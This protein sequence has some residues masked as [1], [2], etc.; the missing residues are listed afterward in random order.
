MNQGD[1]SPPGPLLLYIM[2]KKHLSQ[3]FLFDP[4][5]LN[6]IIRAAGVE[7]G[8][9]VVEI[10]PGPGSLTGL[11]TETARRVVAI[12]LDREL[13]ER[14]RTRFALVENIELVSGDALKYDYESLGEPFRVVANIPYHITTPIMFRLL[15]AGPLLKSMTLTVQKEVAERAAA[16]PGSK[17]YGVLSVMLQ[18]HGEVGMKFVIPR[19]AFRPVPKVDSACLHIEIAKKPRVEVADEALFKAVV[20]ASFGQR[21]KTLKNSLGSLDPLAAEALERAGIDPGRRAETLSI[22]DFARVARELS[23]LRQSSPAQ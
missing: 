14:L 21:R 6:R 19:G 4:T 11:L 12:E 7:A 16:G 18:Y 2:P 9:T 10:G 17:A 1:I 3:N 20:R 22:N 13:F 23:G 15:E 8:D 5:I